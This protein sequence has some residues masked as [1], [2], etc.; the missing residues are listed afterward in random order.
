LYISFDVNLYVTKLSSANIILGF[1]WLKL[2][3]TTVGGSLNQIIVRGLNSTKSNIIL[4][5]ANSTCLS[6]DV[7]VDNSDVSLLTEKYSDVFTVEACMKLPPL[8]KGFDCKINLKKDAVLPF[9]KIYNLSKDEREQLKKYVDDNVEKGFIKLSSSS[10]ASPIFYVKVEGKADRPCVDYCLLND[11]TICDSYPLPLISHL[12]N[13]LQGCEFLSKIDLKAAFNLLRVAPGHEWKTAFR[14]PNGLYE[15][16]VMPFGLA[17]APA[18]FQRFIQYVLREY[19]E[20]FCFFYIDDILIF[21]KTR[22]GHLQHIELILLKLREY[23][24]KASLNKC[25]LFRS[26]V[27]FLGFDI[28]QKGILM[29]RKK[30]DT[31]KDW[32]FPKSI[33]ELQ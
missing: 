15:Y 14:T 1:P 16:L 3:D 24:L 18:T 32:P 23:S 31:I 19:L 30:L 9:G 11:M 17:N 26:E 33:K 12:L 8:R 27:T 22:S 2:T 25:Q 21:S 10:A 13:N 5:K 7:D 4:P 20:V 6:T 29:N 28:S